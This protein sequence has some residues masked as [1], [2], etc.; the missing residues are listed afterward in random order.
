MLLPMRRDLPGQELTRHH[1][2]QDSKVGV[3]RRQAYATLIE[4]LDLFQADYFIESVSTLWD[5]HKMRV[6]KV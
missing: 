6:S 1:R 5:R 2:A 4:G 3:D